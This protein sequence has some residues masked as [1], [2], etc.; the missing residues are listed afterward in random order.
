MEAIR[1]QA[2]WL[3]IKMERERIEAAEHRAKAARSA[4]TADYHAMLQRKYA[5]AA[6][7]PWL[8]VPREEALSPDKPVT[9][10]TIRPR[11]IFERRAHV[12]GSQS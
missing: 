7:R 3:E 11:L 9:S 5:R 12:A 8:S 1:R 10:L 2:E 6:S 4:V